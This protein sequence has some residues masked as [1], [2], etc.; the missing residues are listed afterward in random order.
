[1]RRPTIDRSNKHSKRPRRIAMRGRLGPNSVRESPEASG[2]R[3]LRRGRCGGKN[4]CSGTRTSPGLRK[5]RSGILDGAGHP[6]RVSAPGWGIVVGRGSGKRGDRERGALDGSVRRR[7]RCS[8]TTVPLTFMAPTSQRP[9]SA[10]FRRYAIRAREDRV[11]VVGGQRAG[12]PRGRRIESRADG[13]APT[14]PR[15]RGLTTTRTNGSWGECRR[16]TRAKAASTF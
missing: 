8:R 1:M 14:A 4:S 5:W 15:G 7:A 11:P 9:D 10:N 16:K 13:S 6:Q 12:Q 2:I 3:R